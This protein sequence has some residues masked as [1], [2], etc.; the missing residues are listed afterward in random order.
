MWSCGDWIGG[1]FDGF[2][3]EFISKEAD[4]DEQIVV[5]GTFSYHWWV[6]GATLLASG[7]PLG[8]EYFSWVDV[9]T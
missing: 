4:T 2:C 7:V 8:G 6:I 1:C 9:I 3:C 5:F